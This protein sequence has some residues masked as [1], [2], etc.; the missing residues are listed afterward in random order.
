MTAEDAAGNI[1]A[2]SRT[3][4]PHVA[5]A[6]RA[7]ARPATLAATRPAST[8]A[9]TWGAATD[10]V[11]VAR[12]NLHRW[13]TNGFTPSAANRIAQPTG[14]SYA[15]TGLAAGTLL[16]QLTA[17]DAAGNIGPVSQH[18][19]RDRRRHH[20]AD[21]PRQPRPPPAAPARQR[22]AGPP[23]TDNVGVPRYNVHRSTT[24]GFTP[25]AANRVAQPTGTSYTDTGLAA[26]T[27]YYRSP[28]RTPPATSAPPR[29]AGDRRRH[30]PSRTGL[31]AA[32]GF[33]EGSGTTT[34]DQSG[35]GNTGTLANATWAGTAPAS[36]A[37]RSPSTARTHRQ[38]PRHA[39]SST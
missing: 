8:V 29:N 27:Y 19:Q 10:N 25:S 16:L 26:G 17:E 30:R 2:A 35:T 3:R 33:D 18:G 32:Y 22:S 28:P 13:T 12:Y 31:V 14:L 39:T 34:A 5:D 21:A 9:L 4:P 37:T 36:S 1:S 23:S 15:D 24:N 11:G 6:T 38:R 20:R 7:D